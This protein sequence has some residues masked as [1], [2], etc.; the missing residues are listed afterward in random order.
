MVIVSKGFKKLAHF[1]FRQNFSLSRTVDLGHD[2]LVDLG[3]IPP[4]YQALLRAIARSAL[5][6]LM[7]QEFGKYKL[8]VDL[9]I[10]SR[11]LIG[12]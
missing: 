1:G 11:I 9:A 5:E 7:G 8:L 4:K 6:S 3:H 10:S 2:F 12:V